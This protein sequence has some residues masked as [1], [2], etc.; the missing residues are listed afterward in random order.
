MKEK[1]AE[2]GNLLLIPPYSKIQ[3]VSTIPNFPLI[4]YTDLNRYQLD[5]LT[6]LSNSNK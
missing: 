4:P 1:E 3:M 5:L 6:D 2:T